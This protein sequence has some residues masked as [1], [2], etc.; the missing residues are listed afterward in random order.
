MV[1]VN[2]QAQYFT[3]GLY[4]TTPVVCQW[5]YLFSLFTPQHLSVERT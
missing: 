5:P 3:L 4:N 1:M 2:F